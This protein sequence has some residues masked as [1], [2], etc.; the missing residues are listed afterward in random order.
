MDSKVKNV[1]YA[2]SVEHQD[3][4]RGWAARNPAVLHRSSE[5]VVLSVIEVK[6]LLLH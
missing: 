1:T 2:Y 4:V 6:G 3:E 5:R